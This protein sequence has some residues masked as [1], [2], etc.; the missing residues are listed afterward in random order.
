MDCEDPDHSWGGCNACGCPSFNAAWSAAFGVQLCE[1]CRRGE[2]LIA[3]GQAK[4]A[5]LLTDRW[6]G[7]GQ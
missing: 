5:F 6:E 4:E 2:P 3:K 7:E 1:S